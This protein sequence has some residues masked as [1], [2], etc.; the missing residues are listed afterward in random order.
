M[1][2]I[3]T[4]LTGV[5]ARAESLRK[6]YGLYAAE[7]DPEVKKYLGEI[8]QKI[9]VGIEADARTFRAGVV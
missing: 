8:L 9:S 6:Y 5:C 2:T 1:N 3:E 7:T 4:A